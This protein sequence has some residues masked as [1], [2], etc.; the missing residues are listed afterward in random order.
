LTAA[1]FGAASG[2][3]AIGYNKPYF[4]SAGLLLFALVSFVYLKRKNKILCDCQESTNQLS[5]T[6]LLIQIIIAFCVML[7]VYFLLVYFVVPLIA[8]VVYRLFY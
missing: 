3:L 7:F 6:A 8:P 4:F 2:I 1:G 5:R